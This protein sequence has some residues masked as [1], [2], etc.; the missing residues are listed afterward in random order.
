MTSSL[1]LGPITE[2]YYRLFLKSQ[3][4]TQLAPP[5]SS[6]NLEG[7]TGI[8][9]G[10]N[11]GL[12]F[13]CGRILVSHK[14]SRLILA[15]R[16]Q[17]KGEQAAANLKS[18]YP[19][20]QIDVWSLDML[21]YDSIRKFAEKCNEL[22]SLDFVI[23]NA[24][25]SQTD[26]RINESTGHEEMLQVNYL[27]TILLTLLMLP[28]AKE[29]HSE[30]KP[31]RITVVGSATAYMSRFPEMGAN[32]LLPAFD[33]PTG[34]DRQKA[35]ERYAVSKF[36]LQFFWVKLKDAVSPDDVILNLVEPGWIRGTGLYKNSPVL[37][38]S[39]VY[40]IQLFVGRSVADGAK[41]YVD[42]AVMQGKKSRRFPYIDF[43]FGPFSSYG[44]LASVLVLVERISPDAVPWRI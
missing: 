1:E 7:Q 2:P 29:K 12:G 9:T 24:G 14:L 15:V 21:S 28:I 6:L 38:R 23:L 32:P 42:A 31:G 33:D 5:P 10:G 37:V 30:N 34:W 4:F 25:I 35:M 27:S 13:E 26:F 36:L 16:S 39:L 22:E 40:I 43:L 8:I 41:C 3:L 17:T 18:R 44:S 19:S 11:S 20:V